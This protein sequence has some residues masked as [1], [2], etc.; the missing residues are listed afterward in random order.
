[1]VCCRTRNVQ[2]MRTLFLKLTKIWQR[3][4]ANSTISTIPLKFEDVRTR[5]AFEYLQTT[6]I[7]RN[8]II[9]LYFCRR[10]YGSTFTSFC[11]IML[12]SQTL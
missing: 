3:E 8:Y 2:L 5:N 10:Y 6:Y 9:D 12:E 1:M 7:A 11:V 4:T